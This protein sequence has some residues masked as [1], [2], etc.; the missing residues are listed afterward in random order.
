MAFSPCRSKIMKEG[1][2]NKTAASDREFAAAERKR[3]VKK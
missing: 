3:S 2:S 1:A